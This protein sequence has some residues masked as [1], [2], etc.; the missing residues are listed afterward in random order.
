MNKQQIIATWITEKFGTNQAEIGNFFLQ[1]ATESIAALPEFQEWLT[2]QKAQIAAQKT[3]EAL[4]AQ[5][6]QAEDALK[7]Q[8]K[9]VDELLA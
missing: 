1:H 3:P 4:E 5:K 6:K 7:E 9:L 8:A 2:T